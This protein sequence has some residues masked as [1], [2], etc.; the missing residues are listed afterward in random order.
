MSNFMCG[1]NT[2][3]KTGCKV[4]HT[5]NLVISQSVGTASVRNIFL[6]PSK[7]V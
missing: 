4:E 6:T 5:R 7:V 3:N 1:F 2:I